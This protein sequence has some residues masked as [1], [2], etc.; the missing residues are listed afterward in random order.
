[1]EIDD[2]LITVPKVE[3]E[4]LRERLDKMD[5]RIDTAILLAAGLL[6]IIASKVG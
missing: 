5:R 4:T 6:L 2:I 3:Q 1:M